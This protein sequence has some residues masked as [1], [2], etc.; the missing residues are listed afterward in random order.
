MIRFPG[1]LT[2]VPALVLV[3]TLGFSTTAWA[4][5]FAGGTGEPNDPYQVATAAQLLAIDGDWTLLDKHYVLIATIDLSGKKLS[6]PVISSFY[7]SLDGNGYTIENLGTENNP[8]Q[9]LFDRITET[10][11]VKNLGVVNA[12]VESASGNTGILAG[13]SAGNV[14]NC[15][16]TGTLVTDGFCAGGLIGHNDGTVSNSYSTATVWS[17]YV[18]GG[19]VGRNSG[20]L[21]QC[22][23]TGDVTADGEAGGLVGMNSNRISSSFSTSNVTGQT[24]VAG[25][26]GINS[27]LIASCYANGNVEAEGPLQYNI[28]GL[29]GLNYRNSPILTSYSTSQVITSSDWAIVGRLVGKGDNEQDC[30]SCYVLAPNDDG[31]WDNEIGT[32]LTDEEMRLQA[33]FSGWDFWGTTED[34]W[35]DSWFMPQNAY[36]V[37]AWQADLTGLHRLPDVAGLTIEK[38]QAALTDA[39]FVPGEVSYDFD[40]AVS[41]DYILHTEPFALALAGATVNL[42]A[43]SGSTCNWAENPGDGTPENPYQI[44]TAGQLDVLAADSTLWDKDFVLTADLDLAG[45]TYTAAVIAPDCNLATEGFQ[46]VAF[47]G[48]LDGQG[49]AIRNLVIVPFMRMQHECVGLFGMVAE[50]GRISNLHVLGADVSNG[51]NTE[52]T[53]GVLVGCNAGTVE[54]CSATGILSGGCGSGIIGS[55]SG[56]WADCTADL[57]RL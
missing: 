16:S 26:V 30:S 49:H 31:E 29:V 44:A 56:T 25:L 48:T 15:Y 24:D 9:G 8:S 34:G 19:L 38:A 20:I 33:S 35:T 40:S 23:A 12:R 10:A 54:E 42:I 18:A 5:K 6:E 41:A 27:G 46:G 4:V 55:N 13:R 21:L 52:V 37:L 28:G 11:E 2:F 45:R 7:G 39:G 22:C 53:V 47:S 43:S 51:G 32:A 14:L 17:K 57:I 50:S 36:P 1:Q 3:G